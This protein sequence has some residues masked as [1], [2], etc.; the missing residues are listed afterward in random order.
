MLKTTTVPYLCPVCNGRGEVDGS[1]YGDD[2]TQLR[3]KCRTCRGTGIV[4]GMTSDLSGVQKKN[5]QKVL[6]T[7]GKVV[8]GDFG[9]K[10]EEREIYD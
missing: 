1:F 6:D 7:L 9:K 8:K 2:S 3:V 4:W 5:S 10:S